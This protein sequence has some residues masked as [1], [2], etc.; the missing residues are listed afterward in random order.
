VLR[1]GTLGYKVMLSI[2]RVY[3]KA[4]WCSLLITVTRLMQFQFWSGPR[5]VL[6]I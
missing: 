2:Y 5:S 1:E 4:N 6:Q 3:L